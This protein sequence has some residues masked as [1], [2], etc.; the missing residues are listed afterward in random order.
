[1]LNAY[2]EPLTFELPPVPAH[3]VQSWRR[4]ID[5]AL[6]SPGDLQPWALGPPVTQASYEV[7]PRSIAVLALALQDSGTPP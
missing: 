3:S 6:A 4:C 2:W 5:T 1:M 7:Q